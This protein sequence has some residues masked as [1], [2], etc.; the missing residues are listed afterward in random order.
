MRCEHEYVIH[1]IQTDGPQPQ[2]YA[3]VEKQCLLC[4]HTYTYRLTLF[5]DDVKERA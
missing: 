5:G 2:R 1:I 4:A 3:H